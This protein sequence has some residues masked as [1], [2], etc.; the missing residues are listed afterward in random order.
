[1]RG[2]AV[3][4][5]SV[6][7]AVM[8]LAQANKP[9][10]MATKTEL[11]SDRAFEISQSCFLQRNLPQHLN[12]TIQHILPRIVAE[13]KFFTQKNSL[14]GKEFYIAD[15]LS[16]RDLYHVHLRY[17]GT[18]DIQ[19]MDEFLNSKVYHLQYHSFE[20]L[21]LMKLGWL[22]ELEKL[23]AGSIYQSWVVQH[24]EKTTQT[25]SDPYAT[26]GGYMGSHESKKI[27]ALESSE[28]LKIANLWHHSLGSSSQGVDRLMLR[29]LMIN[30][31]VNN[32]AAVR[33]LMAFR[34]IASFDDIYK[35]I[36]PGLNLN[37]HWQPLDIFYES[38]AANPEIAAEI[39]ASM[40]RT[41]LSWV[42]NPTSRDG[43]DLGLSGAAQADAQATFDKIIA[44]AMSDSNSENVFKNTANQPKFVT[45]FTV[46]GDFVFSFRYNMATYCK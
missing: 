44:L 5:G 33:E 14:D 1:M 18:R 10:V 43:N 30:D 42:G 19:N 21:D 46:V 27:P 35:V 28:L 15:E 2:I 38:T 12:F 39:R 32:G 11:K 20:H 13:A 7:V 22:R 23:T 31:I 6:F 25:S 29:L 40:A 36:L 34:S 24:I 4:L 3:F 37:D 26:G 16:Y 8:S 9:F 45:A 17:P 41:G